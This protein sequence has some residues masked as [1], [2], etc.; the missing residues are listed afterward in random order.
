MTTDLDTHVPAGESSHD[1]GYCGRPFRDEEY[2]VLH[3][4]I[5]HG[6][7]L[8]DDEVAAFR[9]AYEDEAADLRI[10]RLKMVAVLVALYFAFLFTYSIVT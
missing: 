9:E 5:E 4:G 1:C 8:D 2:L 7:A 3:R 6:D 10:F